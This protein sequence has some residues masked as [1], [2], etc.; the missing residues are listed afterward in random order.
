MVYEGKLYAPKAGN[1]QFQMA[2]DDGSHLLIDGKTVIKHDG[3]HGA[4]LKKGG[5]KLSAGLH[6]I[7]V[8][9]FAYGKPNSLRASWS[10][11]G[12]KDAPLTVGNA[13]AKK[14]VNVDAKTAQAIKAMQVGYAAILCSPDFQCCKL[15]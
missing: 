14:P 8:E 5:A 15:R 13:I 10:G 2:S 3:L 11:P 1:Y 6:V 4:S 9:Y 12:F 7:R